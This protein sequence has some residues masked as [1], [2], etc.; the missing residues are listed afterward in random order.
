MH[1]NKRQNAMT[2]QERCTQI[3]EEV[4]IDS[5]DLRICQQV[6]QFK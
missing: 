4:Q 3:G 5:A 6:K 1:T 2:E